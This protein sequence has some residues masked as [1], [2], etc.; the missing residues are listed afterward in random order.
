MNLTQLLARFRL[1]PSLKSTTVI[2]DADVTT[3]L[4]EGA[5]DF[6]QQVKV[7]RARRAVRAAAQ[8]AVRIYSSRQR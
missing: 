3:L 8:Q 2:P 4:N 5:L 6:N 7:L 1:D